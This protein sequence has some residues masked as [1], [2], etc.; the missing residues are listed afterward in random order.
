MVTTPDEVYP[1]VGGGTMKR[2]LRSF[3]PQGLSPRGRGN[4]HVLVNLHF[5]QGS[6]PAWAGEPID[7]MRSASMATVY[8]R[9]GGGTLES[10]FVDSPSAGLSPRGRGNQRSGCRAGSNEGSIPAWAGEP[11]T[12][13]ET[14]SAI[15]VYPRVGG[16]T[17]FL[18]LLSTFLDGLSPRGRGNHWPAWF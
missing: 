15:A 1:R 10:P 16:G 11:F 2:A 5:S 18:S 8:P 17:A 7:R 3:G 9:V 14:G 4:L 6:I 13:V 12:N